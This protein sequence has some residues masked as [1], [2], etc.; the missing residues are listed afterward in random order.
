MKRGKWS[1]SLLMLMPNI[2]TINSVTR[3]LDYFLNTWEIKTTKTCPIAQKI[4]KVG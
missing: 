4:V 1:V 2:G 3:W